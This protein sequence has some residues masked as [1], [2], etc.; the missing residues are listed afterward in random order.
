MAKT[1]RKTL[2]ERE[3]PTY[4]KGEEIFNMVTHIVGA[5]FA[6]VA[7]VLMVV[8]AALRHNTWGV[9]SGAIY[10]ASM[11]LVYVISSVYHG[12]SP[13][14]KAT[15]KKVMQVI[16]HCDIYYLIIGSFAPIALT[17]LREA[18]PFL[19]WGSFGFVTL[20][21]VV[22][23]VFTAI[24]FNKYKW[25]SYGSYF[26]AGWGVLVTLKLMLEVYSSGFIW[27]LIIG[28]LVY[29]SG[30]IFFVLQTK[31]YKYFHSIFHLFILGGTALQF[32][33]IFKYCFLGA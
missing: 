25:I 17:G 2:A 5:A 10:G 14:G 31:S 33:A 18:N 8:F 29:T 30:M 24:D 1:K 9:V 20:V 28:G 21:C 4:T 32:I 23:T 13:K 11:F 12:L 15:G 26:L 7:I 27:L 3:L 22:G 6:I 19:A 16:D